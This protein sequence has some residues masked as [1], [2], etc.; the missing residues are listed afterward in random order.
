M[1]LYAEAFF[2]INDDIVEFFRNRGRAG[3]GL[4]YNVNKRWR[5]SFMLNLQSSRSG[6]ENKF[7]VTDYIYQ[8]RIRKLFL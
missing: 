2:P 5:V 7:N 6:P 3:V 1:P 8:L 4:G